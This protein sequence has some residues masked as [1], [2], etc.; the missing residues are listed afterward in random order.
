VR[1]RPGHNA[2]EAA[3]EARGTTVHAPGQGA[4]P[5]AGTADLPTRAR[6]GPGQ[7]A[8]ECT[9]VARGLPAVDGARPGALGAG[10]DAAGDGGP[11]P[12]R[13]DAERTDSG[14]PVRVRQANIVPEL[15][16][17][18]A[19]SETDDEDVVRPPEQVRRMMSSY[20]TGTRRGRTDAARLLGGASG[21]PA[22][23]PS[24]P[25]DEDPQAT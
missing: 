20:Q 15:R 23:T 19:V 13:A 16:D 1:S 24:E 3:G 12:A 5:A 10:P 7:P 4:T 11:V 2:P 6:R 22:A 9:T 18:P 25:T 14:L 21:A 8:W 17:D